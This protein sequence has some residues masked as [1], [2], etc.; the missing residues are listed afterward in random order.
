[1]LGILGTRGDETVKRFL[2]MLIEN[3]RLMLLPEIAHQYEALKSKA[4]GVTDAVVE[5]AFPLSD[6]Q[7]A[8]LAAKLS[9]RYGKNVHL[10]VHVAPELIGGVRMLVGDDVIDASVR[11]KLNELAASLKN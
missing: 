5:T 8:D 3:N 11:G 9:K 4:E 6:E 7:V 10:D 1:M 2:A